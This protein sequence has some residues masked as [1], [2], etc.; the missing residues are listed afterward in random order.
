MVLEGVTRTY[1]AGTEAEV[2]A[3]KDINLRVESGDYVAIMGPSGSGKSTLLNLMGAMDRPSRG[4]IIIDGTDITRASNTQLANIRNTKIGMVFQS[5]NLINRMSV[6]ENIELP[7]V[8]RGVPPKQRRMLAERLLDELGIKSKANRK[9]LELSG[10][11]QQRVAIARALIGDPPIILADEPTG[12]LSTSDTNQVLE[13]LDSLNKE[14]GKTLVVVTHNPDVAK[15]AE[16]IV[17][18]RDGQ[19]V[20]VE[21][22]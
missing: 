20:E 1:L 4:R 19:I 6:I 13:I 21:E 8:V 15:H 11:Q 7:L 22:A 16:R 3:V 18:M 10:G 14:M 17:H 2:V 12:N 5:F 9:A